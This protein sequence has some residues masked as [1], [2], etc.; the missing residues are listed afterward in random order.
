MWCETL[1]PEEATTGTIL[2]RGLAAVRSA[3]VAGHR[4]A[5]HAAALR[6]MHVLHVAGSEGYTVRSRSVSAEGELQLTLQTAGRV[7]QLTL[8]TACDAAGTIAVSAETGGQTLLPSRLLPSGILPHGKGGVHLLER[9]D[10]AYRENR[11]PGWDTGRPSSDLHQAVESGDAEAV[12][13]RRIRL[14]HG[15]ECHLPGPARFRRYGD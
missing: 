5:R 7:Y 1:L 11:R 10:S 13:C 15:H 4:T 3:T 14:R 6:F 9:W 2:P 12:P 8:P